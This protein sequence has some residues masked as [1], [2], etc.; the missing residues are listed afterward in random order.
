MAIVED[1]RVCDRLFEYTADRRPQDRTNKALG[2]SAGGSVKGT[3]EGIAGV[4]P[5]CLDDDSSSDLRKVTSDGDAVVAERDPSLV[6][7][8]MVSRERGKWHGTCVQGLAEASPHCCQ[9]S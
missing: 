5:V 9:G 2:S 6:R 7:N 1:R 4:M 8:S 3:R